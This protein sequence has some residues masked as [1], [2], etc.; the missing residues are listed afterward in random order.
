MRPSR[1]LGLATL[2]VIFTLNACSDEV[3]APVGG[4]SDGS[5]SETATETETRTVTVG[6]D[7]SA[8]VDLPARLGTL[9]HPPTLVCSYTPD[10]QNWWFAFGDKTCFIESVLADGSLR[11]RIGGLEQG[12]I[13]RI[14]AFPNRS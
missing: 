1:I 11:V 9:K 10:G 6:P 4:P 5:S 8:F 14:D 12:W 3:V 2:C 7:G 13:F